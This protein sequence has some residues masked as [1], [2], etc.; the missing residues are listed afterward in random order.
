M[1][2]KKGSCKVDNTPVIHIPP[3]KLSENLGHHYL[4]EKVFSRGMG[5]QKRPN[6]KGE[7]IEILKYW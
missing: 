2:F 6:N 5:K 4:E 1:R 7:A 3:P